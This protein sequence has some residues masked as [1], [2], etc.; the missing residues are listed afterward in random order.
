MSWQLVLVIAAALFAVS[1]LFRYRPRLL[2]RLG[3]RRGVP[4]D[5]AVAEARVRARSAKT[6]AER[7]EA[8]I[9]AAQRAGKHPSGVTAATGF[10]LRALRA[11]PGST[12]AVAG[13]VR[14]LGRRRP[15]MLEALMWRRLSAVAWEGATLPAVRAAADGLAELYAGPLHSRARSVVMRKLAERL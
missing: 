14:L 6:S 12:E 15:E 10:Y 5:P 13:L 2:T 1:L 8:F 9:L 7:A 3:R 4:L 11:E